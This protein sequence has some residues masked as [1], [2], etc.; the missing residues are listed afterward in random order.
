MRLTFPHMG[1][2]E[3]LIC[4]LMDRLGCDYVVPPPTTSRTLKLGLQHA[5]EFACLPLKVTV[6]N[7]IEGL[8]AG[9]DA[10]VMVGG[11]GPCRFGYYADI[12][13]RII[14]SLGYEF[15]SFTLEPPGQDPLA[16]LRT[17]KRMVSHASHWRIW[18]SF[19]DAF[20][21]GQAVDRVERKTLETRCFEVE[22][23]ATSAVR[24]DALE[25][26]RPAGTRADITEAER[27]ALRLFDEVPQDRSRDVL[28]VGIVG[29][30]YMVLEPFVNFD[31]EEYLGER[32]VWLAQSVYTS[33]W[34]GPS[35]K[36]PVG[37]TPDAEVARAALPYL[38]HSVGGE[39]RATVGHT[40]IYKHEGFDGIVQLL[41]FTCMPDTIAK[42]I[43]PSVTRHEDIPYM[44]FVIDEQT[45]KAGIHTRLEAFLD[46]LWSRRR[47]KERR[48]GRLVEPSR[49]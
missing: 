32:G 15:V 44:T 12:Q 9:A 38:S 23:G 10:T 2:L 48:G 4:D 36:N 42:A 40:V 26:L 5:P 8:E 39:G 34:V 1:S 28:K 7:L 41:P 20:R 47:E 16:F 37:G 18:T 33:D 21:K 13:R 17:M 14:S 24:K 35:T 27:A 19:R 43:L 31:M 25:L 45:G 22:R 3:M 6:G 30:F 46:L 29:E 49:A 11:C